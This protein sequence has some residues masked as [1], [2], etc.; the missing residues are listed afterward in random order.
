MINWFRKKRNSSEKSPYLFKDL[1][2]ENIGC[3]HL[4]PIFITGV[5]R[6]G[7]H[8]LAEVFGSNKSISAYHL[9]DIGNSTADSFLMY[10]KWNKLPVDLAPFKASRCH[11]ISKTHI[12]GHR[13]LESNPYLA[14][15]ITDLLNW[16]PKAKFIVTYRDPRECVLSHL[17]KG[18]YKNYQPV[19]ES[20]SASFYQYQIEKPNHFFGRIFPNDSQE[21][22]EWLQLSQTGRIAWMWQTINNSIKNQLEDIKNDQFVQININRFDYNKYLEVCKAL[23]ITSDFD[24]SSFEKL[25]NDR[26]AQ[27]KERRY[28][29]WDM[30]S[31]N[32][33]QKESSKFELPL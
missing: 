22:D 16:F 23:G 28:L 3:S 25:R 21:F 8:F 7:T 18:W 20:N 14:F 19:K 29:N 4:E 27:T 1:N 32:D 10:A 6:S 2:G 5:G 26:P 24:V 17:N 12:K 15:S 33:F 11:L 9:D 31:E 30:L 13:F